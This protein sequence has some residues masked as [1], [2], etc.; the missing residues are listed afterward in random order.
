[1]P[2]PKRRL[3]DLLTAQGMQYNQ[4]IC[5]MSDGEDTIRQLQWYLN[6]HSA[7]LLDWFHLTMRLTVLGQFVKGVV[8]LDPE[9]GG[10]MAHALERTK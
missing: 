5:F 2:Q 9:L 8:K 10:E 7:H 4:E 1:M 3:F 6:P